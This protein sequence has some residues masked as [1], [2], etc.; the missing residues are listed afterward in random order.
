MQLSDAGFGMLKD[1]E[2]FRTR[3]YRDQGGVVT[4]GYGF[5]MLSTV[6]SRWWLAHHDHPLRMGDTITRNEADPVL[7]DID[8]EALTQ[9]GVMLAGRRQFHADG[10][11]PEILAGER[12]GSAA[13]A[14][15]ENLK[16]GAADQA[17]PVRP[18]P[19]L[20]EGIADIVEL[21]A[22]GP[23]VLGKSKDW[24]PADALVRPSEEIDDGR[25]GG[26][27]RRSINGHCFC[28]LRHRRRSP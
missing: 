13:G 20:N 18:L 4:I 26:T 27:G 7:D 1:S 2:G 8:A 21:A 9:H 10:V 6:F 11:V 28:A 14:D 5:T 24:L 22:I 12:E 25:V 15:I 23:A 17:E 19:R 16:R 3:A